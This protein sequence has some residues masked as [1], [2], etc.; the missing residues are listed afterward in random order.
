MGLGHEVNLR[1]DTLVVEKGISTYFYKRLEALPNL[2]DTRKSNLD[3]KD[4]MYNFEVF[5]ETVQ[6]HYAFMDLNGIDWSEMYQRYKAKLKASPTDV[7]LYKTLD[8][9]LEELNDNHAYLEASD[10]VY[11]VLEAEASEDVEDD[12]LK[13]YGDFQIAQMAFDH[14]VTEDL[15][16]D[17]WLLLWGK[18]QDS[19]GYIQV[20]SMWLFAEGTLPKA[21]VEELGY[22][23]AYQEHW[24]KVPESDYMQAERQ[25]VRHLME[26]AIKDLQDV[27]T[28][29]IDVRF[30]GGGQDQV[31]LEILSWLNNE[32]RLLGDKMAY[33]EGQFGPKDALFLESNKQ[34]LHKPL[35]VLASP[36]TGSAA[37]VFTMA[38]MA[39]PYAKRLGS[40]TTG[41]TSDALA[42]NLPNGWHFS[43]SNEYYT[44]LQ[45]RNF[46]N[47][48]VPVD[49]DM[50]YMRE[51]QPFFRYIAEHLEQDT[52]QIL[53]FIQE[54]AHK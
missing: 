6:S 15:T 28:I 45:G 39:I 44:N 48:G 13:N 7:E 32:T 42:K 12:G 17:S 43:I 27:S 26:R 53:K 1:N 51:R 19:I 5:A 21:L 50:H 36:Q 40:A 2:C 16:K 25:G 47:T 41:A 14:F 46:E 23:D 9:M 20:K 33:F 30:N 29:V 37:E 11:E 34:A 8:A 22:V 49:Y 18:R 54:E 4:P 35:Y 52:A 3:I 38:S 31:S 24:S 10:A